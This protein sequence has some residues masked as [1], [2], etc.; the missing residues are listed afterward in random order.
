MN[1]EQLISKGKELILDDMAKKV[2]PMNVQSFEDLH[3]YVDANGY[4]SN[5]FEC[6]DISQIGMFNEVI[7]ELSGWINGEYHANC[8]NL[9][10]NINERFD[11]K[12]V[13]S[14]DEYYVELIEVLLPLE[15]EA[16]EFMLG[17]HPMLNLS[18]FISDEIKTFDGLLDGDN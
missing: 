8:R 10:D 5:N 12:G 14:L 7:E 3:K 2:I 6:F 4:I 9:M 1:K 18:R 11:I 16:C 13:L 17:D 15:K